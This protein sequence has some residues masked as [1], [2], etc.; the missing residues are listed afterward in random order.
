MLPGFPK[1]VVKEKVSRGH[2]RLKR[3]DGREVEVKRG[4][5]GWWFGRT[6]RNVKSLGVAEYDLRNGY[7]AWD[8]LEAP[9][10]AES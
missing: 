10:E 4:V 9:G 3:D 7:T 2:Y 8:Q 1:I 5:G 6:G